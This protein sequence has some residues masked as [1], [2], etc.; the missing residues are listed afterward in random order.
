MIPALWVLHAGHHL[1]TFTEYLGNVAA[2]LLGFILLGVTAWWY[3]RNDTGT[4]RQ[5]HETNHSH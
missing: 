5:G 2:H 1:P 4:Q 3:L